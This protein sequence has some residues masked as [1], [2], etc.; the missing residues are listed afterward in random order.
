MLKF[1]HNWRENRILRGSSYTDSHWR[2]ALSRLPLLEPLNQDELDRLQRLAT[3]FLHDKSLEGAGDLVVTTE[4]KLVIALQACLPILNLGLDW[5]DGWVS[6]VIYPAGFTPLHT[7]MDEYGVVHEVSRPLSG[8]S[9][10]RG[11]VVLSAED[12]LGGGL[13]D[14]HNLVIHEFAH[15][16]D[17]QNGVAN[18]MPPLHRGMSAPQWSKSFSAA[19][20]DLQ[21][22]IAHGK[23]VAIDHYAATAP[24]E[25]FAVVSEVFFEQPRVVQQTYPA[26]YQQL[27]QF[28]R[29][30]PLNV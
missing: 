12:S 8:E 16:L 4:L 1:L 3:L 2:Q 14:G 9:W 24:A 6:V 20:A 7:E 13:I 29:Q 28:Y 22:R 25:F 5:Y 30:D 21:N 15:K 11:P 18:G 26:V 17:M 19:Y 27:V 23:S 10:E